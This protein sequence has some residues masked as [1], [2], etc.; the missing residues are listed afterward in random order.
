MKI[1]VTGAS[2]FVGKAVL[3]RLASEL[4]FEV[5]AAVRR[6][7]CVPPC[8]RL[9]TIGDIDERTEWD[10][11]LRGQDVVVHCA[12]LAH[13]MDASS[14]DRAVFDRINHRGSAR[15]ASE[16]ARVGVRRFILISSVAVHGQSSTGFEA[17]SIDSPLR[18]STP[19]AVSKARAEDVVR[20]IGT[21]GCM[22]VVVIRPPLVY[23]P[24]APGNYG[25]LLRLVRRRIPLPLA[26][27]DNRRSMVGQSNLADLIHRCIHHP[28]A[29]GGTFLASDGDDLSTPR[30]L[31]T[32]AV[33]M[34]VRS[35]LFPAPIGLVRVAIRALAGLRACEQLLES[36]RID[37]AST[38]RILGWRPPLSVAASIAESTHE[39]AA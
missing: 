18:P 34:G 11:A 24:G 39:A 25:R 7:A 36:F 14:T 20:D 8:A 37:I 15:L 17:L 33:A 30:L 2:G 4:S 12:G 16:A 35:M 13:V 19:Y 1:L 28:D 29:A 21:R 38:C 23:G 9:C 6:Y 5:T 26:T 10:E 32:M 27:V 31:G 3:T 22:E